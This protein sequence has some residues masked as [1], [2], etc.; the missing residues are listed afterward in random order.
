MG[1]ISFKDSWK[2]P[3]IYILTYI[4]IYAHNSIQI[5]TYIYMLIWKSDLFSWSLSFLGDAIH[6]STGPVKRSQRGRAYTLWVPKQ[7]AHAVLLAA[8]GVSQIWA[9]PV[10]HGR[11]KIPVVSVVF[12][13][14]GESFTNSFW[15]AMV[16][17][18]IFLFSIYIP[19]EVQGIFQYIPHIS[20]IFSSDI[21]NF[22]MP[23]FFLELWRLDRLRLQTFGTQGWFF[24][25]LMVY[26]TGLQL[27]NK[28]RGTDSFPSPFHKSLHDDMIL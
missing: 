10:I 2:N 21:F 13:L 1:T 18:G 26:N 4:Y 25:D 28:G 12:L 14:P 16:N 3:Y 23:S 15:V 5:Y 7:T 20:H 8:L 19:H 11:W 6:K 24:V 9:T 22:N 17:V 27:Q